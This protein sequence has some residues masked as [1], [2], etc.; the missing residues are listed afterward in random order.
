M[1]LSADEHCVLLPAVD[2]FTYWNLYM[3]GDIFLDTMGWSGGVSTFEAVAL[4]LPIVTLPGRFM[5]GRQSY[6]ILTQLGVT[7][8]ICDDE[9]E[10]VEIAVRLGL[11]R[12]W[13]DNLICQMKARHSSLYSDGRC[14]RALE[15]FYVQ[16]VNE[17]ILRAKFNSA[18]QSSG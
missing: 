5:R 8:T 16:A 18:G 3:V 9:Q 6:A 11:D 7:E 14:V 1:G 17:Q 13:R 10:Y 15:E 4:S 12:N 2:R